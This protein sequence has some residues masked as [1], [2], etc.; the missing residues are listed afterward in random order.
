MRSMII[1]DKRRMPGE[2]GRVCALL[3]LARGEFG[4]LE[5]ADRKVIAAAA[6][7]VEAN[8]SKARKQ[9]KDYLTKLDAAIEAERR[10]DRVN[11]ERDHKKFPSPIASI[12]IRRPVP[13]VAVKPE[14]IRWLLTDVAALAFVDARGVYITAARIDTPLNLES[15]CVERTLNLFACVVKGV[16]LRNTRARGIYFQKTLVHAVDIPGYGRCAIDA[17]GAQIEGSLYLRNK[18]RA[19]GKVRLIGAKVTGYFD[20]SGGAFICPSGKAINAD[21]IQIN[22]TV[23]LS[24]K[25]RAEGEV[26]LLGAKIAGALS[27]SGGAFIGSDGKALSADGIQVDGALFVRGL[28]HVEGVFG[29]SRARVGYLNDG[30]T[31][32]LHWPE[33]VV[34]TGFSYGGIHTSSPLD[35]K[36]RLAWLDCHDQT[37][38]KYLPKDPLDPQP[39]QQLAEVFKKQ[40]HERS[41]WKVLREYKCRQA[42]RVADLRCADQKPWR[43]RGGYG[44][45]VDGELDGWARV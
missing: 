33:Q 35:V 1:L 15:C 13:G 38:Q 29:F 14:V 30:D 12:A 21:S 39:Y 31:G 6:L 18:F 7:G 42:R 4:R 37:V 16:L 17:D 27:C 32:D 2:V 25:F 9:V 41:E 3:K 44:M 26:R 40:G 23:F 43:A 10:T 28:G 11:D 24:D 45:G 5:W 34:L 20:C 36:S 22:G 8:F 19:E